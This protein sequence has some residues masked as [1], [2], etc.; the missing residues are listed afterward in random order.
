MIKSGKDGAKMH[1]LYAKCLILIDILIKMIRYSYFKRAY[2]EYAAFRNIKEIFQTITGILA[3]ILK[4][5]F[6][7]DLKS[8]VILIKP[9]TF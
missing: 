1:R 5:N 9:Y 4:H 2:I 6:K 8:N 7:I 3:F